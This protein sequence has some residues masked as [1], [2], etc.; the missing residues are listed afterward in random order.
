VC[1]LTHRLLAAARPRE[2]E[3]RRSA[4]ELRGQPLWR[5]ATEAIQLAE[6]GL[7]DLG[8]G[9][10]DGAHA[11]TFVTGANDLDELRIVP[12]V[13]IWERILLSDG[14]PARLVTSPAEGFP[15]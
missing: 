3:W 10:R 4:A 12:G 1:D 11:L 8:W 6:A 9:E 5:F 7:P 13:L 2:R 14:S 15:V